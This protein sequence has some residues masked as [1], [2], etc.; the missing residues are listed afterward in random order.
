MTTTTTF[1]GLEAGTKSSSRY[2][3]IV[4]RDMF[5]TGAH[6]GAFETYSRDLQAVAI[7]KNRVVKSSAVRD[8]G[9]KAC[10]S[11]EGHPPPRSLLFVGHHAHASCTLIVAFAYRPDAKRVL[12]HLHLHA[13]GAHLCGG[14]GDGGLHHLVHPYRCGGSAASPC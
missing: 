10:T 14:G 11:M 5:G 1:Q 7:A 6:R 13:Y 8:A 4:A 2:N 3:V 9:W 12:N